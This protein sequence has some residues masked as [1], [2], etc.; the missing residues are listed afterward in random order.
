MSNKNKQRLLSLIIL[1]LVTLSPITAFAHDAVFLQ[2]VI[3]K[4][5]MTYVGNVI[6]D[7]NGT[8]QSGHIE[9]R[10]GDFTNIKIN[11][12][13]QGIITSDNKVA[14]TEGAGASKTDGLQGMVFTFPSIEVKDFTKH[15]FWGE[16]N[17]ATRADTERALLVSNLLVPSLN[18]ALHILNNGQ[19][20]QSVEKLIKMSQSMRTEGRVEGSAYSIHY[21]TYGGAG[22]DKANPSKDYDY[23]PETGY[24]YATIYKGTDMESATEKYRFVYAVPKGYIEPNNFPGYSNKS[25]KEKMRIAPLA[26][27]SVD[28]SSVDPEAERTSQGSGN[29][30]TNVTGNVTTISDTVF[31]SW[32]QLAIQANYAYL[33]QGYSSEYTG[34]FQEPNFI[35]QGVID[36][37]DHTF[38]GLRSMLGLYSTED[39]I[40]NLGTRSVFVYGTMSR[41]WNKTV[42]EYHLLFQAIAWLILSFAIAKAIVM[43]NLST[44]SPTMRVDTM[45]FIQNLMISGFLLV[46][47]FPVIYMLMELNTQIVDIFAT[48]ISNLGTGSTMHTMYSSFIAGMVMVVFYFFIDLYMNFTYIM[49]SLTIALLLA[50]APLFVVALAFGGRFTELF[51]TWLK[52]MVA[53][54][55]LQ[56]FHAFCF[57]FFTAIQSKTRGIEGFVVLSAMIPMTEFFRSLVTGNQGAFTQNFGS[58]TLGNV[59]S[60]A[61]GAMSSIGQE[62]K[63][64]AGGKAGE[65]AGGYADAE[66]VGNFKSFD[67]GNKP[68]G[69]GDGGAGG[70]VPNGNSKEGRF[71]SALQGVRNVAFNSAKAIGAIGAGIATGD[72]KMFRIGGQSVQRITEDAGLGTKSLAKKGY[73]YLNRIGTSDNLSSTNTVSDTKNLNTTGNPYFSESINDKGKL[74]REY[75]MEALKAEKMDSYEDVQSAIDTFAGTDKQKMAKYREV[76]IENAYINKNGKATVRYGEGGKSYFDAYKDE[77]S[78]APNIEKRQNNSRSFKQQPNTLDRKREQERPKTRV[79]GLDNMVA[80]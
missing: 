56:S 18:E 71:S 38:N 7:K 8:A 54:I 3:D 22:L 53:N 41:Q 33:T 5:S 37:L 31:L 10:L 63:K 11:D 24:L 48:Q 70:A 80:I 79:R 55:F 62:R 68:D 39:L 57:V 17:N 73:N 14:E 20:Y 59:V 77:I 4:N 52:E 50:S 23:D 30:N 34:E 9:A 2:V 13:S 12:I 6:A 66:G 27:G 42:V 21:G 72:D 64:V 47:I 32:H 29:T 65:G 36:F 45:Q 51:W 46:N 60:M 58:S 49:R 16:K 43:R 76:G 67:G 61:S 78:Y 75:D 44:I 35:E 69:G 25:E 1:L 74:I 26:F 15:A 40:Y 28:Y 19:P